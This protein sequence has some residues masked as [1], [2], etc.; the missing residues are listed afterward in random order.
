MKL[1]SDIN[2]TPLLDIMLI[3]IF[4][5][6]IQLKGDTQEVIEETKNTV[7]K[8]TKR[9]E[10]ARRETSKAKGTIGRQIAK[11]NDLTDEVSKV[12]GTI[13]IKEGKIEKLIDI[14]SELF[15]LSKDKAKKYLNSTSEQNKKNVEKEFK[16][17][18][19]KNKIVYELRLYSELK[20]SFTIINLKITNKNNLAYNGHSNGFK[21]TNIDNTYRMIDKLLSDN[22]VK[23]GSRLLFMIS[24]GKNATFYAY[25]CLIKAVDKFK[26]SNNNYQLI[27]DSK[28]GYL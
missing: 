18:I 7:T 8:A 5:L 20:N 17:F 22:K 1:K 25:N 4:A 24:F 2:L 12:K 28:I 19:D 23:G 16:K 10:I 15:G 26:Q 6:M 14:M 21:V 3:L 11:I 13:K 9:V 27:I